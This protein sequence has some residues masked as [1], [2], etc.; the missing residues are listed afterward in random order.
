MGTILEWSAA[1]AMMAALGGAA[2]SASASASLLSAGETQQLATW[3]GEGPVALNPIYTK[4]AG[5][6]SLDFH[7][8]VDGKG[9]TISVMEATDARGQTW[10]VGGYNPQSWSS[11]DGFHITPENTQRTAFIFNLT[12]A[13]VHRQTPKTYALDTVGA[14]Q[15]YNAANWGPTFGIGNDLYVPANLSTG[16]Y[17]VLYS[18]SDPNVFNFNTSLL[19]G[20]P[21]NGMDK[22]TYGAIQVYTISAVPELATYLNLLT[23]LAFVGALGLTR[24]TR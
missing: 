18:Y 16:G 17:S 9:R 3:L 23:G 14:Y 21:S 4:A 6:T 8:A 12:T 15:T 10:L 19:D 1:A 2:G 7:H 24:R 5:D 13:T 11:S 22:I 20:S